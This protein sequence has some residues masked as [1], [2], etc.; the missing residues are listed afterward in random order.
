MLSTFLAG[1]PV[2]E[3]PDRLSLAGSLVSLSEERL[4]WPQPPRSFPKV[5]RLATLVPL[6][7]ASLFEG[8]QFQGG[9]S[10]PERLHSTPVGSI[11][12]G[13]DWYSEADRNCGPQ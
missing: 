1:A 12:R 9:S 6:L 5:Q 11:I 3:V 8:P 7:F 4:V 13:N 2:P 10:L